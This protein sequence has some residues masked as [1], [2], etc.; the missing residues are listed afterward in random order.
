VNDSDIVFGIGIPYEYFISWY[1]L[2]HSGKL[3][4]YS[5]IEILNAF[6][7]Q[8]GIQINESERLNGVIRRSCGEII[9][10]YR[11]L[12]GRS[13]VAYLGFIKKLSV[14]NNDI[15]KV[16]EV[17]K[18]IADTNKKVESLSKEN[19]KL[20]ERCE[21]LWTQIGSLSNSNISTNQALNSRQK[22]H[23]TLLSENK[24]LSDY[25]EKAGILTNFRNTGKCISELGKKQQNR[26]LTELKTYVE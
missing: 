2:R 16:A 11:K 20:N 4:E 21:E 8:H 12:K 13:K 14:Y 9:N 15:A 10:K 1:D 7:S 6:I 25:L 26:N 22:D 19:E 3:G 23:D 5:L 24:A 18:I 17:Q